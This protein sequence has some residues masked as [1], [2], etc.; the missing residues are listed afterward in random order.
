MDT[1]PRRDMLTADDHIAIASASN[2]LRYTLQMVTSETLPPPSRISAVFVVAFRGGKIL[3]VRLDRGWDIPG[4]HREPGE[5]PLDALAREV[6]EEAGATLTDPR[7]FATLSEP[8][9]KSVMVLY[10]AAAYS[11]RPFASAPD[12]RERAELPPD[13]FLDRYCGERELMETLI[14]MAIRAAA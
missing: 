11:L 4:G 9:R 3:A 14:E 7:P 5:Q 13:E 1:K 2:T 12:S 8:G 10:A 6:M